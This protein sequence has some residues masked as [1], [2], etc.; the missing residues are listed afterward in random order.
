MRSRLW[1]RVG[2]RTSRVEMAPLFVQIVSWIGFYVLGRFGLVA[3]AATA[4]GSLRHALALMF[5]FTAVSHFHPR[6]RAELYAWCRR[7]FRRPV[8]S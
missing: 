8:C 5:A 4:A 2:R 7:C 6:V 1:E 3:S